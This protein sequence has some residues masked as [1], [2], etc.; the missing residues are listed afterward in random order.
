MFTPID[1]DK[2]EIQYG[3]RPF[4]S[5]LNLGFANVSN[6]AYSRTRLTSHI[7]FG[8]LG[9][10]AFGGT[11]QKAIHDI[12]PVGWQNQVSNDAVINYF[13]Q[14]EKGLPLGK[15]L[16]V[17]GRVAGSFGT[18]HNNLSGGASLRLSNASGYFESLFLKPPQGMSKQRLNFFAMLSVD[19]R[20]VIYDATLQGGF[21]HPGNDIYII[22]AGDLSRAVLQAKLSAGVNFKWFQLEAEHVFLTPEFNSGK[23]HMWSRIKTT[24]K[25]N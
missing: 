12:E 23:N 14:V 2:T 11:V 20:A 21:I 3:D 7:D 18:L 17:I 24:F 5:F 25:L 15:H 22:E 4:S 9:P 6:N 10:S 16:E 13:I 8:V 1:P 19:G